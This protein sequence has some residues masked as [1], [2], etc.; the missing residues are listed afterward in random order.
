MLRILRED[1]V[2]L[3]MTG[4]EKSMVIALPSKMITQAY[5]HNNHKK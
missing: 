5:K 1:N 4:L 3:L 2:Y